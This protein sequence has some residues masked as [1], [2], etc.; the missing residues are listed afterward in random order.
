M[1]FQYPPNLVLLGLGAYV[2]QVSSAPTATPVILP[3]QPSVLLEVL[4]WLC[5]ANR[6]FGESRLGRSAR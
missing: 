4:H 3:Q 5:P 6:A 1:V 2:S